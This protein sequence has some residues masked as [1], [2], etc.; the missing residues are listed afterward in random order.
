MIYTPSGIKLDDEVVVDVL[1]GS[2]FPEFPVLP[3]LPE[4]FF[5][6]FPV[7]PEVFFPV[8]PVFPKLPEEVLVFWK[9]HCWLA[10]PFKP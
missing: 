4:E 2:F 6:G 10:P 9:T 3:E 8:F 5:P 7:I 1:P